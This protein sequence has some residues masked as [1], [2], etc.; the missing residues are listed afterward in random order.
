MRFITLLFDIL[1]FLVIFTQLLLP[2][3]I[4]KLPYFWALKNGEFWFWERSKIRQAAEK[5]DLP[6]EVEDLAS[7]SEEIQKKK[8]DLT[9][10]VNEDLE[11]TKEIKKKLKNL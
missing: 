3:F 10:R 9:G 4:R 11:K 7:Q 5:K 8:E 2:V 1:I 6:E